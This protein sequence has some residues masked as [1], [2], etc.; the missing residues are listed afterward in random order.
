MTDRFVSIVGAAIVLLAASVS[1]QGGAK[2]NTA[3]T[4]QTASDTRPT[5]SDRGFI[6]QALQDG[7]A[8]VELG[9]L[10]QQK[11]SDEKVK[12]FGSRMQADHGKAGAELQAIATKKGINPPKGVGPHAAMRNKLEKTEGAAFDRAYMSAMVEDH[13]K[14]V[15]AFETATKSGDADVSAF[16]TK[17]LPTLREHH[18]MAMEINKAVASTAGAAV[19]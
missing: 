13:A 3:E 1:G 14:A 18:R 6:T 9:K 10:A 11:A 5:A 2:P 12:S 16:A 15:K 8:E 4:K 7:E 19:K 17:T